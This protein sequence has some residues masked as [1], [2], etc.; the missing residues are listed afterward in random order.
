MRK[1]GASR[2]E[3]FET[4]DR[5]ALMP[6]PAEPY[7]YAEWRRARVAPDYHVEVHGHFYSVP[8]RLIR[9]VVE[10]RITQTT[11]EVFHRGVRVASHA[12]SPVRRRHTTIPE[13]MP[14]AHR[15]YAFWTPARLLAAADKIGPST[16]ALCEAIMRAKPHPEQGFRSCLG[17]LSLGRS[18]GPLASKRP[19]A[20][21]SSSARRATAPSPRSS[22]PV[23]T[24]PSC[25][26]PNRRPTRSTTATSAAAATTT[27][28][29]EGDLM[30]ANHSHERLAALGLTGMAKAFDDQQRQPDVAALAFEERLGLMIDREV[31]E[32][33]NK[34]LVAR[35]KFAALRQ[36]AVVEDI[37]L[38]TPRG[39]ERAFF[40]KLVDGDW[41]AR[42]HNLLITGPTGVGKTWIACALGHK[43]CRDNRSVLYHRMPRMFEALALARGDGRHARLLKALSRVELLILDDWGLAPL[44]GEQR[45]DLLEIVDDRHQRG[46]TIITSQVPVDHW[47]EVIADP[48]IADA[49]LDRLVHNAH[50]LELKGDSMRKIAAQRTSLDAANK[51]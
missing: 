18:Y 38:R 36:A 45:R 23:S 40:A 48:T 6:L 22:R 30:L 16:V 41:I 46:S 47:H 35:L 26:I 1:L 9:Q 51:P 4:I 17:I 32:R 12:R 37:D 19:A 11:V 8:S 44:T 28:Q 2:R 39:I 13:H 31:T 50:R 24:R 49:V 3:F 20:A 27:D 5:P 43:A 34:R 15:R 7:Q 33:D 42:K 29:Q 21:A 10:V 25:P 14:S